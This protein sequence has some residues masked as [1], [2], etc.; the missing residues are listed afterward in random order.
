MGEVTSNQTSTERRRSDRLF[1]SLPLI[2]RGIDLLGQPFEER[3]ATLA[4]NLHGCRYSSKHH[5]PRNTWI[6]LELPQARHRPNV[7]A[8]VA[9][10]QR[11]HSIR[12]F[13]QIAVELEGPANI[14]GLEAHPAGW[15]AARP[16]LQGDEDLAAESDVL[17]A[18]RSEANPVPN[19]ATTFLGN[20]MNPTNESYN[21]A[22]AGESFPSGELGAAN[23]PLFREVRKEL[24]AQAKEAIAR[25]AKQV[26]EEFLLSAEESDRKRTAAIEEFFGKWKLQFEQAQTGAREELSNQLAE[27]QDEFLR[28]FKAESES[29]LDR[30][31][32]V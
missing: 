24:E 13:F 6:T 8:R 7:R 15:T 29:N 11:P 16:S 10:V 19:H 22:E 4:F 25:A 30:K 31:S 14:W 9:W 27:R 2:V 3:T 17:L 23:S 26:Q 1:E 20:P 12:D 18:E 28:G 21:S 32:V 5:L